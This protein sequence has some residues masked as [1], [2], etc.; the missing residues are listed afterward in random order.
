MTHIQSISTELQR[1][2]HQWKYT[3]EPVIKFQSSTK[4]HLDISQVIYRHFKISGKVVFSNTMPFFDIV[5]IRLTVHSAD[6]ILVFLLCYSHVQKS[7]NDVI[8]TF[9][10][11]T[12]LFLTNSMGHCS[13]LT[14]LSYG[15]MARQLVIN[16]SHVTFFTNVLAVKCW[17][18]R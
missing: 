4:V 14:S 8:Q 11:V 7:S 10:P 16:V 9:Q 3:Q 18:N 6:D 12:L 17:S 13:R 1:F 2:K 15:Y 5:I